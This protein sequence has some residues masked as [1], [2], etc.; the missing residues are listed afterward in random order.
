MSKKS[1]TSVLHLIFLH[2]YIHFHLFLTD[3]YCYQLYQLFYMRQ[4]GLATFFDSE[5]NVREEL[6]RIKQENIGVTF[7]RIFYFSCSP[8]KELYYLKSFNI[9]LFF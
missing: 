4:V 5:T 6:Y 2:H 3:I 9:F 7:S 1:N 8:S